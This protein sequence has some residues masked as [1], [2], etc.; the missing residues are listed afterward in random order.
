MQERPADQVLGPRIKVTNR[1]DSVWIDIKSRRDPWPMIFFPAWWIG[2][3]V[4]G[5]AVTVGLVSGS[6][7]EASVFVLL[8]LVLWVVAWV[9]VG[10]AWIWTL[11][12]HEVVIADAAGL[13]IWHEVRGR[14]FRRRDFGASRISGLRAAGYFGSMQYWGNRSWTGTLE[15]MGLSGG[16]IAFEVAGKT[17]RLGI[18]LEEWE[19]RGL[20]ERLAPV[21]SAGVPANNA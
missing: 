19:A 15:W 13:T 1:A 7:G 10:A 2:W 18:Q 14:R 5:G 8:W 9:L 21:L 6:A 3:T 20:V 4:I 12:G 17:Q 16:T 11:W